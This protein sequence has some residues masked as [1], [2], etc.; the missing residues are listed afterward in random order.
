MVVELG[1]A[2]STDDVFCRLVEETGTS[3]EFEAVFTTP[4]GP[5]VVFSVAGID[6]DTV[7]ASF[8]D[9][10][11]VARIIHVGDTG[12]GHR[13]DVHLSAGAL[14]IRVAQL[15]ATPRRL[16]PC[17]AGALV[18]VDLPDD[19][20]VRE[21]VDALS[22]A[23][24]SADLRSRRDRERPVQTRSSF[25]SALEERLTPRQRQALETA[26]LAGYFEWPRERTSAEVAELLGVSQP[27]FNRHLRFAERTLLTLLYEDDDAE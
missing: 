15:E 25:R 8:E 18:V 19:G 23:H 5:T 14:P 3:I 27:T 24:P 9:E 11:S 2:L 16:E 10:A 17:S 21:F 4:E 7:L 12:N 26:Y 1:I 22:A 13:Y 6:P 20:D